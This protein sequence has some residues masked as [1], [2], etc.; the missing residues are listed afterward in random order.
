MQIWQIDQSFNMPTSSS[1]WRQRWSGGRQ[2]PSPWGIAQLA[3]QN[4]VCSGQTSG[5]TISSNQE[6]EKCIEDYV[7]GEPAVARKR[8]E[9][10]QTVIKQEQEDRRRAKNA[11]LTITELEKRFQ[12]IV[13]SG[14]SLSNLASSDNEEDGEDEYDEDT[15]LGMLSEDDKPSWVMGTLCKMVQ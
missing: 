1:D 8:V 6:K 13:A 10:A 7:E 15:E 14:E 2:S 11:G 5:N 12:Q 9:D 4:E 3:I